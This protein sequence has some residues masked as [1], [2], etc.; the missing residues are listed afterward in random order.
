MPESSG[1]PSTPAPR[2]I[3][4][5][6]PRSIFVAGVAVVGVVLALGVVRAAPATLTQIAIGAIIALALDPLVVAVRNG[7]RWRRANAVTL[8]MGVVAGL[9]ASLLA[10]MGPPAIRQAREFA[11][12]LPQTVREMYDFPVV[13]DRL[14]EADAADR[15]REWAADLPARIDEGQITRIVEGL[16]GG[17]ASTLTVLLVAVAILIDGDALT[18]RFRRLLPPE[19]RDA[20]DRAGRIFYA[21]IGRYF[22]GSLLV[23]GIAGMFVLALGLALG[24]PLAPLAA[25]WVFITD[26]IPQIGGFLGGAVFVTLAVTQSLTI[27][28]IAAVLFIV[29]LQIENHVL[30]PAIVGE[31]VDLSPPTT[32]LAALTGGAAAG[33][34][35]ALIATPLV[36]TVKALYMEYRSR[37]GPPEPDVATPAE[38]RPD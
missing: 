26:L 13:G 2:T 9:F 4:D 37:V 10:L 27:G 1:G 25:I 29:Y 7:L 6:S 20:A 30:Q 3:L 15:V 23:A 32:M 5:F 35:G 18:R 22:A 17:V 33:V 31:R 16:V 19:R 21:V 38:P 28:L 14:R 34:P 36:G 11:D 8:V 12:E 24:V